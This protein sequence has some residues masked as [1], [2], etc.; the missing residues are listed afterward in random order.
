MSEN[1]YEMP[2]VNSNDKF[3]F[4]EI[5][6]RD[7][8]LAEFDGEKIYIQCTSSGNDFTRVALILEYKKT[9]G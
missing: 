8:T 9:T 4:E 2:H 1:K 3:P 7:G 6:K 5:T